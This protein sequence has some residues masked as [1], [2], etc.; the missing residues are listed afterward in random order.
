[1]NT[2]SNDTKRS[3]HE[4]RPPR[5]GDELRAQLGRPAFEE[6]GIYVRPGGRQ[7]CIS[8]GRSA[9]DTEADRELVEEA[10][11]ELPDSEDR[12]TRG[13]ITGFS[14]ASRRRLRRT[15]HALDRSTDALFVTL[16]WHEERPTPEEAHAALDRFWKRLTREHPGLSAVWKMEPQDRGVPHFHL[17]VYGTNFLPAQSLSRMWH[18]CTAERSTQHRLAGADVE[19]IQRGRDGKLMAYLSKYMGKEIDGWPDAGGP[20]WEHPG[21]FWGVLNREALPVAA[22]ADWCIHLHSHE[23]GALIAMLL[24]EWGVELPDGVVPPRL[25]VNTRGDP[26]SVLDALTGRLTA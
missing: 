2:T 10:G 5:A 18:E 1:M 20:A 9:R 16:T 26:E 12:P 14:A 6:A 24:D 25:T 17:I 22:W 11:D 7:L 13:R 19:R 3:E 15:V 23:A 21:R 8:Q 4:E